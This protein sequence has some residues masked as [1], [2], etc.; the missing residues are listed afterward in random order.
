MIEVETAEDWL[1]YY[2]IEPEDGIC[3]LAGPGLP[4]RRGQVRRLPGRRRGHRG[5][6]PQRQRHPRQG[7]RP[8]GGRAC[9]GVRHRWGA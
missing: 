4:V 5:L 1:N 9:L 8:K 3:T 6:D 2:G 7:A